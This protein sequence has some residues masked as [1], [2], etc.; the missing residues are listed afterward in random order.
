MKP[1]FARFDSFPFFKI[2]LYK[3][4]GCLLVSHH[5]YYYFFTCKHFFF[6]KRYFFF[7]FFFMLSLFLTAAGD[8]KM[9]FDFP[10][11]PLFYPCCVR[12][13]NCTIYFFLFK[14]CNG[15]V[16]GREKWSF[17]AFLLL[18]FFLLLFYFLCF[19]RSGRVGLYIP[20]DSP[21]NSF[22]LK[23][24]TTAREVCLKR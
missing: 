4:I 24:P 6:W 12:C 14:L 10:L 7:L 23:S 5:Y 21:E 3:D 19:I 2:C 18:I 9:L 11:F 16:R 22:T 20:S 1:C 13:K 15:T 8:F 17:Y